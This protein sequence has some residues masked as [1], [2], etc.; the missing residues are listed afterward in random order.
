MSRLPA[1]TVAEIEAYCRRH[2]LTN[3]ASEHLAR[4][5]E[6]ADKAAETGRGLPR[7]ASKGDEPAHVFRVPQK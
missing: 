1:M 3:F 4:F 6:H 2:G 7:L 5:A